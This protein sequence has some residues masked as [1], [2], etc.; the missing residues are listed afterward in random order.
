M[1]LNDMKE[2]GAEIEQ[3]INIKLD[4]RLLKRSDVPEIQNLAFEASIKTRS[5]AALI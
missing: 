1:S 5:L 4:P 2:L 3:R